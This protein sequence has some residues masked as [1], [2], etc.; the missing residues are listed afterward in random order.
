MPMVQDIAKYIVANIGTWIDPTVTPATGNIFMEQQ[1][2]VPDQSICVYQLPGNRPKRTLGG[3]Y[4]WEEP[5]L[6]VVNRVSE[7]QGYG[8]AA[9]DAKA[10]WD[11]LRVVVNQMVNGTFYMILDPAGSPAPQQLDPNNQI[12]RASCRERV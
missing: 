12:G 11:L 3:R 5:R 7:A 9:S 8:V 1:P 2:T 4:A 10:I 6:R